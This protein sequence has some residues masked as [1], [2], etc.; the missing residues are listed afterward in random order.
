MNNETLLPANATDAERALEMTIARIANVP[1]PVRDAWNP[2]TC[3]A[4]LLPWLAWAFSVDEWN[5]NWT[6]AEKRA[7]IKSSL[8]VHKKKG[9]LSALKR[10]VAPLGYTIR[11]YE[12]FQ[13]TPKADPYTFR[14]EVVVTDT[15]VGEETF[16]T[17]E[18]LV[19]TYK[20]VRSQMRQLTIK[21][22]VKG[23]AYF[24]SGLMSGV[25]TTVYPYIG[26]ELSHISAL[27][28]GAGEQS[29]DTIYVMPLQLTEQDM[30]N[31]HTLLH[32]T[33]PAANYW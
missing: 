9:T 17:I 10:A 1:V 28:F 16:D 25:D 32:E 14:L 26:G 27:Y 11:I 20:N 22:E 8:Y 19:Q 2:D 4:A 24:A 13:D 30:L 31:L 29:V 18:R 15:G 23:T 33:M 7:V 12:W 21:G 6:E 5:T 3:P